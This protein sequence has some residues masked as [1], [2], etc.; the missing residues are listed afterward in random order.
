MTMARMIHSKYGYEPYEW[1]RVDA[2]LDKWLKHKKRLAEKRG[3][4]NLENKDKLVVKDS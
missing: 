4:F 1:V 3:V 2:R